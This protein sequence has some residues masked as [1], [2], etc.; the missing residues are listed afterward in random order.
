MILLDKLNSYCKKN[1]KETPQI[2][3]VK[4]LV[5][6]TMLLPTGKKVTVTS[7]QKNRAIRKACLKGIQLLEEQEYLEQVDVIESDVQLL[8]DTVD[9]IF[10]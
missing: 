10:E 5:E 7:N 9:Q 3:G 1:F 4:K 8:Q 2:V 6:V